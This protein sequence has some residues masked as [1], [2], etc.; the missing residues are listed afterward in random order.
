MSTRCKSQ[1]PARQ[2]GFTLI[3]VLVAA[4]I[5]AGVFLMLF[6]LLGR[7]LSNSSAADHIRIASIADLQFARFYEGIIYP[8]TDEFVTLDGIQFRVSASMKTGKFYEILRLAI[9]RRSSQ[10]TLGVFYGIR[11]VGTN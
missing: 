5:F 4:V 7:V 8:D 9:G 10:D 6:T 11:Y 3:E 1:T 2:S